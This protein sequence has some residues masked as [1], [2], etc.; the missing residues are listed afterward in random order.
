MKNNILRGIALS[1]A[2]F[3]ATALTPAA[4]AD[5]L[6]QFGLNKALGEARIA[7]G[8]GNLVFLAGGTLLPMLQGGHDNR[9]Q[10]Y[11]TAD[12]LLT[13]TLVSEALKHTVKEMRPDGSSRTSFPSG[14]ATAAFA[15][16]AMQAHF[17]PGQALLWYGGATLIG[18]SRVQLK[19]HYWHDVIAGAALGYFTTHFELNQS[20]GFILRP[21][22][23]GHPRRDE[24]VGGFSLSR[25]F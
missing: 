12:A 10:T 17:H 22:I 19:R 8:K 15:V 23:K 7:S 11:R 13:S 6:D 16:A 9:Q 18:A 5:S 25:A 21:F 3:T 4:H 2:L 20:R 1:G 24:N 14:H